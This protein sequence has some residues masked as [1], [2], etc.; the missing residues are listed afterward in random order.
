[1]LGSVDSVAEAFSDIVRTQET[2]SGDS[3]DITDN[4]EMLN[5]SSTVLRVSSE[6]ITAALETVRNLIKSLDSNVDKAV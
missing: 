6:S 2:I 5:K 4:I 3:K 1:M